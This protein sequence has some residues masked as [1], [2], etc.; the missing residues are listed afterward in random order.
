MELHI[1]KAITEIPG[2]N[3]SVERHG[4]TRRI[5]YGVAEFLF[6]MSGFGEKG[7]R[8]LSMKGNASGWF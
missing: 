3:V 4:A 1:V 2:G 5:T 6:N 8:Q 7:L